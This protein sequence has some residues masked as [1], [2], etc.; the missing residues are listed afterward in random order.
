MDR[1]NLKQE[2]KVF[3][4]QVENCP[5]GIGEAFNDLVNRVGGSF[6]RQYYGI[7]QM[8]DGGIIYKA[9]AEAT[10]EGEGR[11]FGFEEFEI[12]KGEY[13]A[14]IIRDWRKKTESI[15]DVFHEMV[16]DRRVDCT[17]PFVEWY[18]DDD[19]MICMARVQPALNENATL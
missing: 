1:F 4:F 10:F 5:E 3:G 17:K 18:K 7:S 6:R 13:L 12:E 16:G 2:I 11:Q 19:E 15:K 9:A 8:K 14:V